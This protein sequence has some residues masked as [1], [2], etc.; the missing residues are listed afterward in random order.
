MAELLDYASDLKEIATLTTGTDSLDRRLGS[1][2]YA[3]RAVIPYDLA[4]LYRL[5]DDVLVPQVSHGPLAN[6]ATRGHRLTLG[7][8]PTVRRALD[9]GRP[10]ALTEED[11]DSEEGD[12]YDGV[13][14]LP[15]GHACM[16]IPLLSADEQLGII[17]LDRAACET[18]SPQAVALADVYGQLISTALMFAE[19]GQLLNR[20]RKQLERQNKVLTEPKGHSACRKLELATSPAMVH[21]VGLAKQVA[22]SDLPVL[23][24]GETGAGKEVAARA[25]HEWSSRGERPFVSINCAAIPENL[26]ESELFGHK[27]GAFSGAIKDRQGRFVA[28]N[29]GTL[30]LDEVG[31]MPLST[32]AKLLRVLQEGTFE[33]VGSDKS[34][35]VDVRVV[36]ASHVDLRA[37]IEQGRFREDLYYRLA[38]FPLALPPLRERKE[39]LLELA[40]E[41][42]RAIAA[43]GRGPWTLSPSARDYLLSYGWPGNVRELINA[44]E[45]ASVLVPQGTIEVSHLGPTIAEPSAVSSPAKTP[46]ISLRAAERLHLERALDA[47]GGKIYGRGGAAEMLD[48][49]PTTLQSKLRKHGLR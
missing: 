47:S 40:E 27:K 42:L 35:R 4:V 49:K 16:V 37:A 45:R 17:T 30:L 33:P 38:A 14:D 34:V 3:L 15:S 22:Q 21:F 25:I 20:Y 48:V 46:L 9:A 19:Q 26:V 39:D 41:I 6:D 32:Q 1:A 24:Q 18:Y 31:D 2:L 23:I 5:E 7:K 12:P 8:F 13:L 44:L 29:G 36:A 28:A 10:V 11:H 43:R